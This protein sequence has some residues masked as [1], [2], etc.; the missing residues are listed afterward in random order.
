[1]E[2]PITIG[3]RRWRATRRVARRSSSTRSSSS[4]IVDVDV[5]TAA[6]FL[7]TSESGF[8]EGNAAPPPPPL[9]PLASSYL[10]LDSG[11]RW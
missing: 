4:D 1:V 2:M 6:F 7:P 5:D 10:D 8:A 3:F 9:L 11:V